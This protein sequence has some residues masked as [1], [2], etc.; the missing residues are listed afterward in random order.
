MTYILDSE[1]V[2]AADLD[3]TLAPS[4]SII[5]SAMISTLTTWLSTRRFAVISGGKYEQ[6]QKQILAQLPA[7]AKLDNLFLFPTNGAACYTFRDGTWTKLYEETLDEN[8]RQHITESIQ[9]AI[10]SSAIEADA[11]YGEQI[12]YRGGEVSFSALGQQAPLELK[13]PWDPDQSKRKKIVER[14]APLLLGYNISIG[15]TT[16]IDIT[17]YGVDKAYAIEKMKMLLSVESDHIIFFGDAL[18]EGGNDWPA[19]RTGVTAIKVSGPEDTIAN[20]EKL[21]K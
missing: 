19:T 1:T 4:K 6:F 21:L 12:E 3:G 16:T 2:I 8:E 10:T 13:A 18:F 7:S 20:I 9:K 14:L 5:S 17:R 11:T 15:G